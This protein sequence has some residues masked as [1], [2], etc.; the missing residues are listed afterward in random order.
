MDF[1]AHS[2]FDTFFV[3]LKRDSHGRLT[4]LVLTVAESESPG[5]VFSDPPFIS[6][7]QDQQVNFGGLASIHC[8]KTP[9]KN[10][11]NPLGFM[12]SKP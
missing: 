12:L 9:G 3:P 2:N 1:L 6:G 10:T 11:L 8:Q 5:P 7:H 4:W